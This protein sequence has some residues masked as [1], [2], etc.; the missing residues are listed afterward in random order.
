M[1]AGNIRGYTGFHTRTSRG[2]QTNGGKTKVMKKTT[3]KGAYRKNKK[4]AWSTRRA[5]I[6]ETKKRTQSDIATGSAHADNIPDGIIVTTALAFDQAYH[7]VPVWS[8]LSMTR[9]IGPDQMIGNTVY[10]KYLK[11]RIIITLGSNLA[12]PGLTG[13]AEELRVI[14]GWV[15]APLCLTSYTTPN[16][17]ALDRSG[18]QKHI[19]D[20]VK[21]FYDDRGD[22]LRF[23]PK[24]TS[25]LKILG[26]RKIVRKADQY[27]MQ[28][29][30]YFDTD[31]AD[32]L[33][34]GTADE[35]TVTTT[36]P[37]NRKIFYQQSNAQTGESD[38]WYYPTGSWLPFVMFY[39][40]LFAATTAGPTF[41]YNNVFYFTDS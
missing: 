16:D 23:N 14:H 38:L 37:M 10:A 20:Q 7:F 4:L 41:H 36:W 12:T 31:Q 6:V 1:P 25:C 35:V 33:V 9:G 11:S 32:L 2:T 27:N 8:F 28:P 21:E 24:R 26:N 5:P 13:V 39:S 34:A 19:H 18:L 17:T 15:T 3:K 29:Q 30:P 22:P 40:P